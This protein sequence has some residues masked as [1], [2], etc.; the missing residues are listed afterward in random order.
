MLI[1]R[2]GKWGELPC[3]WGTLNLILESLSFITLRVK[4]LI[5]STM[6]RDPAIFQA[7][8]LPKACLGERQGGGLIED[9]LGAAPIFRQNEGWI[10]VPGTQVTH[11]S[12]L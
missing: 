5:R 7:W 1:P 10:C 6:D 8:V 12:S 11:D 4:S 9:C 3:T 2:V